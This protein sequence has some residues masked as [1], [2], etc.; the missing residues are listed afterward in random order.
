MLEYSKG[1]NPLN[2]L[3]IPSNVDVTLETTPTEHPYVARICPNQGHVLIWYTDKS[4]YPQIEVTKGGDQTFWC[5]EDWKL[6]YGMAIIYPYE[7]EV[8]IGTVKYYGYMQVLGRVETNKIIKNLWNDIIH[9]FGDRKIICP[10]GTYMELLHMVIN[11]KRIPRNSYKK[12]ILEPLGF[13]RQG[14]YWIR[15]ANLLA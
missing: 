4:K 3:T 11:Q 9:M 2:A 13:K 15:D 12:Q 6:E 5:N 7:E 14:D 8:I 1:P 10:S